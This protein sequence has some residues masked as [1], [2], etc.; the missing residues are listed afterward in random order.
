MSGLNENSIKAIFLEYL[1]TSG[2]ICSKSILASEYVL[3]S[4]GRRA[5]LA[6]LSDEFVGVEVKSDFDNLSRLKAQLEAYSVCFDQVWTVCA[7]RHVAE[8]LGIAPSYVGVWAV[9][10]DGSI[11]LVQPAL[12]VPDSDVRYRLE[13]LTADQRGEL[14][15]RWKQ[16]AA[17]DGPRQEGRLSDIVVRMALKDSFRGAF[18]PTSKAFWRAARRKPITA[19][20]VQ[21]LSR[22]AEARVREKERAERAQAFWAQW[23]RDCRALELRT[24]ASTQAC[25]A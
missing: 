11:S 6:I 2:Q 20:V 7:N 1:R 24:A 15:R 10:K 3:G 13:L 18:S 9:D 19:N 23:E 22:F 12:S 16:D 17:V 25:M 5:D 21:T 4:L 14:V 8:C